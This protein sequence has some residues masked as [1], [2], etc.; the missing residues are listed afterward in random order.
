M[1]TEIEQDI[2]RYIDFLRDCGYVVSISSMND[3]LIGRSSL[4]FAGYDHHLCDLCLYMKSQRATADKCMQNK[5]LLI[6]SKKTDVVYDCCWAG[7]EEY[8]FPI[9]FSDQLVGRLHISGYRKT[10]KRSKR[11]YELLSKQ[12][13]KPY[14]DLYRRL[15]KRVP[16]R[17]FLERL[18]KAL[19]YMFERLCR[20]H[21]SSSPE[22]DAATNLYYKA[23]YYVYDHFAEDIKVETVAQAVNYSPSYLRAVFL[24]FNG[25]TLAEYINFARLDHASKLLRFTRLPITK[26]AY[27]SGFRD[28][29]Y[30]STAF[31]KH[32]GISPRIYRRD[33]QVEQTFYT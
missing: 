3:K 6:K 26:I 22:E 19:T 25:N 21:L 10:L 27:E 24:R 16:T 4:T 28:G 7:V 11:R 33:N 14:T 12:L 15:S 8:V 29:N 18:V 20:E 13:G 30:F 32:Y 9:M 1:R 2:I 31:K 5:E 17:E 23:L